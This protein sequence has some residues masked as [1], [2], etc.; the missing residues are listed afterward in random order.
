MHLLDPYGLPPAT[1]PERLPD[2]E[3]ELVTAD[4]VEE[5]E[6]ASEAP[7]VEV[8]EPGEDVAI[9]DLD[10]AMRLQDAPNTWLGDDE[11]PPEAEPE[12]DT[13][14]VEPYAPLTDSGGQGI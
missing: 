11:A 10:P 2:E 5:E 14:T 6:L 8:L 7:S 13:S 4:H 12:G 3:E 1:P 9:S